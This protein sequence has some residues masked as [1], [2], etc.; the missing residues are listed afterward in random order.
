MS[1]VAYFT[2]YHVGLQYF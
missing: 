2:F 1:R